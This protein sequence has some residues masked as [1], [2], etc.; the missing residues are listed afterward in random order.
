MMRAGM[1]M[2]LLLLVAACASRPEPTSQPLTTDRF[3]AP[4]VTEPRDVAPYGARPCAGPLTGSDWA[5]LGFGESGRPRTLMTGE[6]SCDLEGPA[7]ERS[8]SFIVVPGRDV[9]VDTY[10]ARQFALFRPTTIG[11]LPATVEQ[12]FRGALT[13]SVTVGTANG[14]GFIV[15][16]SEF[17][18]ASASS[19]SDP[20]ARGQQVAERIVAALPP[21][22]GK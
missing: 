3:G 7:N 8:A 9:L 2:A 10:R 22:P 4:A 6:E 21:L 16:Y 5:A 14:Q 19:G 11:G 1:L 20:C 18:A 13:C 12:S 15:N 17:G